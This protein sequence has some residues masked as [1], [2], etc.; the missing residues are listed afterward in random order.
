MEYQYI[1]TQKGLDE[2]CQQALACEYVALDTEFVRTRSYYPKLGLIQL[3]D[4]KQLSLIDALAISNWDSFVALLTAENVVKVLHSCS[5]DL[6]VFWHHMR[7]IP[8][9]L[10]DSQFAA[11]LSGE[12]A[13]LGYAKLVSDMLNVE[14][15]KGESRTDWLQRP[16]SSKQLDYAANDVTYL[17]QLYP[18]LRE[19]LQAQDPERDRASW[20]FAEMAQ[21]A[22]KKSHPLP[23]EYQ[24][25]NIKN[26]WQLQGKTLAALKAL[27][28]WRVEMARSKDLALNFVVREHELL[29]VARHLPTDKKALAGLHCLGGKETR[30]YG[31]QIIQIIQ[32]ILNT[33]P[34]NYPPPV[35][36]LSERANYK[37][38]LHAVRHVCIEV[39]E[40]NGIKSEVFAS[41][42][43]VNQLLKWRWFSIN[44]FTASGIVPD[45]ALGWRKELVYDQ[46]LKVLAEIPPK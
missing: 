43:Q 44:E 27:A 14:L 34:E 2:C 29:E 11:G 41:K 21:L 33:S 31:D 3:F 1:D 18:M 8:A 12:G 16:L 26:N 7:A 28:A 39:A 38:A 32:D 6:E 19:K 24:Y 13:S 25:L 5:E 37:K 36:R 22:N 10:F 4:G 9:P 17:Y 23:A 30:L 15:D 42:N 40:E 20:V 45:L 35:E 46:V